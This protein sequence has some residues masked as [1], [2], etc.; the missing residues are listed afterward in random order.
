M[1]GANAIK[2]EFKYQPTVTSYGK[3]S[4]NSTHYLIIKDIINFV[5]QSA[6]QWVSVLKKSLA[7]FLAPSS[8]APPPPLRPKVAR[9]QAP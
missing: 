4:N 9:D 1:N 2:G 6:A 5:T 8:Q 3:S 7:M